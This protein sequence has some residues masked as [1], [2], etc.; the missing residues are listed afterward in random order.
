MFIK[1]EIY[2]VFLL[3]TAIISGQDKEL[4]FDHLTTEDGLSNNIV[5]CIVQDPQGFMWF[6]TNHGLSR[7]D[8]N[9]FKIYTND[10]RDSNSLSNSKI[11]SMLVDSKGTM[12]IGTFLGINK[13]DWHTDKFTQFITDD[14]KADYILQ[15]RISYITE[16]NEGVIWFS[17]GAGICKIDSINSII[18][19]YQ[20]DPGNRG[21]FWNPNI[22]ITHSEIKPNKF[23]LSTAGGLYSFESKTNNFNK[24]PFDN[25]TLKRLPPVGRIYKDSSKNIWISGFGLIKYNLESEKLDHYTHDPNDLHSISNSSILSIYEDKAGL[26][27]LGTWMKGLIKFDRNSNHFNSYKHD[28]KNPWSISDSRINSIFEDNDYNLWVGTWGKGINKV[29]KWRKPFKHF[30]HNVEDKSSIG[31]G[32]II[33]ICEDK[34]GDLWTAHWGSGL[35]R[36]KS[37]DSKFIH[38]TRNQTSEIKIADNWVFDM[39]EDRSGN[40]WVGSIGID[41]INIET[42]Q[43]IHYSQNPKDTNSLGGPKVSKIYEDREGIMWLGIYNRGLDRFDRELGTFQHFRHNPSDSMSLSDNQV[44]SIYQDSRNILWIG[45]THGL[46]KLVNLDNSKIGFIRYKNDPSK[47]NSISDNCIYTIFEDSNNRLWFGTEYGLNLFNRENN[48]FS[49]YTKDDGLPGNS[50][51]SILEDD[52]KN[53][54]LRTNNGLVKFNLENENIK[55]FDKRDGLRDYQEIE[56]GYKAFHK[57]RTGKFYYGGQNSLTV[58]HPDSLKDNPKSP[59]IVLTDFRLN[60][61]PV[62]IGKN[63]YLKKVI[64]LADLIEL[65]YY[66]NILSIEFAALDYTAPGKNI[67]A[68]KMEG[69][70][71][72]WV[73]TDA[74]HRL[75]AYTNLDPGEYVFKVKGSN[76]DGI[77]NE[78]GKSVKVIIIPPWW[79]TWWFRSLAVFTFLLI[80]YLIYRYRVNQLLALERMRIQ[81]ASDLHDDVGSSLTKIAI[82]SEI[83][84]STEDRN[85]VTSSSLKIG[86][87]SREIISSLSDIIWSI[88]SRNDK[89]GD[90]VDRM[91]DYL[92]AVFPTGNINTYFQTHG[93]IFEKNIAQEL[94]QNIYLIFK[95]AV[96]NAAKHSNA[97][98]IKIS[99]TNGNGKFRLEISDNGKGI[100]NKNT[101]SGFHGLQNMK[102]RSERIGGEFKIETINGTK[103]ILIVKDI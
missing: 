32:E 26:L 98:E 24:N 93:L 99:M 94:R 13:Y 4:Q 100:V 53:L 23:L 92:D 9:E 3:F 31:Y 82:H 41:H 101:T 48:N 47:P 66:E 63:S 74:N 14:D 80:G 15:N 85:K 28:N 37:D 22:I 55:I 21:E 57:G 90:L 103:I 38:Y 72:D 88:D 56:W 10:P 12:W 17:T 71:G 2:I 86:T 52:N 70:D 44:F 11:M 78:E 59:N 33:S 65:P 54:W 87:M 42:N 76:C 84:Q 29:S 91:R 67:Y 46:N 19:R 95:E 8:G 62:E 20:P 79:A 77:W 81:I 102:L 34:N 96:N 7:W 49:I 40:I 6:G 83:I 75:A 97:T 51:F 39:H 58:F 30:V 89:V 45:T 64:N 1:H 5:T 25:P 36:L 16:D 50:I 61:K 18:K 68:Y 43:I 69:F 35:N 27:W 60:N 73:Y